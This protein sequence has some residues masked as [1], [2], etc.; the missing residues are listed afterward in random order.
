MKRF[1]S[2]LFIILCLT[3]CNAQ[4]SSPKAF[5]PAPSQNQLRWQQ[6]EYYAFI[7][8]STNT[9]TNQ[10]WGYGLP[11]DARLFNPTDLDCDQW[12]RVCKQAGMKGIIV[13]AKHH[14]GFCLWPT[15]TTDYSIKNSPWKNGKG[16]IIGDL[17]KACKKYGLKLGIYISP[18]DRNNAS[19][20]IIDSNG[21]APYVKNILRKQ[22]EECLTK[23]GDIFEIWFDGANGGDG[24]YGG[25]RTSRRIDRKTYYDWQNTYN[26]IR[27]LQPKI[28][29][30]NDNG[31]RADLRWV[32]TEAGYVGETNWS[33]LNA[34]GDVPEDMLRHGVENG[35][36]WVPGEV[37]TSIRPGWFYH[38]Y[39][40]TK[41]KTLPHLMNTFYSS[42]GRN[43]TFLLN[44]PIDKRGRIHETDEKV[45]LELAKAVKEAFAVNLALQKK[46]T[47][48]NVRG[49]DSRFAANK[50]LDNNN[51]TYW[52]TDDGITSGSIIIDLGKPTTFNNFLVQEYI[53]LGQ[54]VKAFTLE[55]LID[56]KWKQLDRQTTIGY[57]R[58]LRFP[59]VTAT[60]VRLTITDAKASPLIATIGI[61]N[62]P[63]ILTAPEI[64]RNQQGEVI[65]TAAN[66][67]SII[68]YTIDGA[69]PTTK[70]LKYNAPF[71]SNGKIEVRAIAFDGTTYKSSPERREQFGVSRKNWKIIGIDDQKAYTVL[72]GNLSTAWRQSKE[73]ALPCE[74][75]IDLGKEENLKGFR[76]YPDQNMWQPAIIT[77]YQFYVSNDNKEWR[78][79][80][81]GEFSNI[82]NN[83]LW[84]EKYFSTT[85]AR[86]VKLVA[87]KNT[88]NN[89]NIGYAEV[90]VITQ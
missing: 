87:L 62:A 32:G 68:Y 13:T 75:V 84:Q 70:S 4:K 83:P 29:I 44:F 3:I 61:Y 17:A 18:W 50:T 22:I 76:Y 26:M 85:K 58:I 60:Q 21:G 38:E 52:A 53:P 14:S 6:M 66:K 80:D 43:G 55:A 15:E 74:L 89:N 79:A 37:N 36:S 78:L 16:D 82:K 81:E 45:S 42:I 10:E 67:E 19:Y 25:A 9:F 49:N 39:E 64:M 41:V 48:G 71:Q 35:D 40:D 59:T 5:G 20:G 90:D 2:A 24:Y 46:A 7:H 12:A 57:K 56:G 77:N 54:R 51:E 11:E 31:D 72:D 27:K 86:Y 28:V 65:I 73:A 33:L 34:K 88:E 63:Q 47:A 8:F 23:Y 1:L 69:A 30:W